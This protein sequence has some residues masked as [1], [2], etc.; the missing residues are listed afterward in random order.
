MP[1]LIFFLMISWPVLEVASII[2]VDN[3]K[4]PEQ[5]VRVQFSVTKEQAAK[6]ETA[7]TRTVTY[8]ERTGDGKA[9]QKTKGLTFRLE[10]AKE[11]KK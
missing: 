5:A 7:K 3:P 10:P 8:V 6:I 1:F 11:I 9:E 4:S 2:P